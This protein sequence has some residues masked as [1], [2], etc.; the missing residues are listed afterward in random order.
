MFAGVANIGNGTMLEI[1]ISPLKGT[2]IP[3]QWEADTTS[4]VICVINNGR[5]CNF[6]PGTHP[7]RFAEKL[8]LPRPDAT[9]LA[10]WLETNST[11]WR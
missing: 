1:L 6:E 5:F 2:R 8:A 11:L 9:L 7:E 4:F 10:Q 3:G